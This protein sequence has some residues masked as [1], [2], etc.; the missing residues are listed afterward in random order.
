VPLRRGFKKEAREISREVRDEL[1]IDL[2]EALD[3]YALAELYGI[4][5]MDLS[6]PCLPPR[7]VR[8]FTEERPHV[9]SGALVPLQPSGALIIE[10]HV[11]HPKRRRATIA[12]EMAHVLLEHPFGLTL[13]DDNGCRAAVDGIEEEATELS[14]ELL[15]PTDAARSAAL[16]GWSDRLVADHFR[17]SVP[18]ARWR[19]NVTGARKIA[20]RT[21]NRW[22]QTHAA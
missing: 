18:M 19:M 15:V 5:I 21:W 8:H 17:V 20:R 16:K 3:P 4:E 6:N 1:G 22:V 2:F 14:G 10:N 12:H 9:F 7:S 11:H 13:T